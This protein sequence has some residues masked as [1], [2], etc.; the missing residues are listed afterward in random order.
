MQLWKKLQYRLRALFFKRQLEEELTE[1]IRAHLDRRTRTHIEAG[2]DP[3]E[4][5]YAALRQFGGV[6]Q[7][8]EEAREARG[9]LWIEQFAQDTIYGIRLLRRAPGFSAVAIL[10]LALGIGATTAIFSVVRGVL[11]R[12]LNYP[13]PSQ[14]M[15]VR[16]RLLP[17]YPQ[18]GVSPGAY[19]AWKKRGDL[20]ASIT[21]W[22]YS[23][24]TLTGL[25]APQRRF[26]LRVMPNFL[27]TYGIAPSLGRDFQASDET[28]EQAHVAILGYGLWLSEFGGSPDAI[29]RSIRLDDV[30]YTIVGVAPEWFPPANYTIDLFIP[31]I[32]DAGEA[33]NFSGHYLDVVARLKSDVTPKQAQA[34]MSDLSADLARKNPATNQGWTAT[35]TPLLED[36]VSAWRSELFTLL[37]AVGLLLIIACVNV[38]NLLLARASTRQRE[39]AVR[40]ALGANR[41]RILRQL[42]AESVLLATFGGA[43]G[44]VFAYVA[45]QVLLTIA[46]NWLPRVDVISIDGTVLLVTWALSVLTGIIFGLVPAIHASQFSLNEN[47]KSA[48]GPAASA[49]R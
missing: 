24:Y 19:F 15:A 14:L 47:L 41:A 9:V 49:G 21:A 39:I 4:A 45:V 31:K 12:P 33:D 7:I 10:T 2:A 5:R 1:E 11:L 40:A 3:E 6:E 30:P 26:A 32:Y 36:T 23:F 17:R 43:L 42:L 22:D 20:F 29:G 48:A 16:E 28:P 35:L 46:P 18:A 34:A 37:G 25:D 13:A 27:A 8:K 44:I 38:A